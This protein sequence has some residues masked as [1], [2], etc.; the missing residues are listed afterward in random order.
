MSHV[1]DF[2][3]CSYIA[4]CFHCTA[5]SPGWL[6]DE[7]F[8]KSRIFGDQSRK[9]LVQDEALFRGSEAVT[10]FAF[11]ASLAWL[12]NRL[13][14]VTET[15]CQVSMAAWHKRSL[16][17]T[18]LGGV[19]SGTYPKPLSVLPFHCVRHLIFWEAAPFNWIARLLYMCECVWHSTQ[20]T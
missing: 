5:I 20:F 17:Y 2:R 15:L 7:F 6:D 14:T 9:N 1:I 12:W 19:Q 18:S 13:T 11:K 8:L 3:M 4:C 10:V 16:P